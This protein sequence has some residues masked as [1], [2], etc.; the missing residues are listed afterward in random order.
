MPSN[1]LVTREEAAG[2]VG[3]TAG[4]TRADLLPLVRAS[5]ENWARLG[6]EALTG[7]IMRGDVATV[8]K[9][10]QALLDR[11]PDLLPLCDAMVEATR[12]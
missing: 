8:T 3:A 9:H 6:P 7:P 5:V 10:R 12:R 1:F 4:L 2:R 11:T